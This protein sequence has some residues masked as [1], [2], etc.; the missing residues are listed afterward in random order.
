MSVKRPLLLGCKLG[1]RAALCGKGL[2]LHRSE[3]QP[4]TLGTGRQEAPP[5]WGKPVLSHCL[6]QA[7]KPHRLIQALCLGL[8]PPWCARFSTQVVTGVHPYVRAHTHHFLM[9]TGGTSIL[10]SAEL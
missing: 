7:L 1:Q 2:R 4:A 6:G 10:G 9:H 8:P 3:V 5:T